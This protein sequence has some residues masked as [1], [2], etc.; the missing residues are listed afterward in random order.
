MI[1][2]QFFGKH[3]GHIH[4][5]AVQQNYTEGLLYL[6]DGVQERDVSLGLG[7]FAVD[8]AVLSETVL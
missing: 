8:L 1:I 2:L 4:L 5:N 7:D 3:K 6:S